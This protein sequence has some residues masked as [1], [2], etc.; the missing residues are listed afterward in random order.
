MTSGSLLS[1]SWG[2]TTTLALAS[3]GCEGERSGMLFYWVGLGANARDWARR[4]GR[5]RLLRKSGPQGA[6]LDRLRG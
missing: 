6:V 5:L 2:K 4:W 1:A 3:L